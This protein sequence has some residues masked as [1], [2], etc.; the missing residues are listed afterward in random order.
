MKCSMKLRL[1]DKFFLIFCLLVIIPLIVVFIYSYLTMKSMIKNNII[2]S[3]EQ[4]FNQS[5]S[6]ISYKVDRL[7]N[8]I[9]S[10]I[11]DEN[12]TSIL[13]KDSNNYPISEQIEDLH[14]IRN[15]VYSYE[16][17][18]DI[19]DIEL[20][21]ND[22]FIFSYDKQNIYP[23]SFLE[24]SKWMSNIKSL[25]VSYYWAPYNYVNKN[26]DDYITVGKSIVNPDDYNDIIGYL[27]IKFNKSDLDEIINKINS[28]EYSFSCIVNSNNDVISLSNEDLYLKYKDIIESINNDLSLKDKNSYSNDVYIQS[29]NI[30]KTDWR[31]INIIP[32]STINSEIRIQL[33]YLISIALILGGADIIV[34]Y[35][36]FDSINTRLSK[37]VK[38]M[39]EVQADNLNHFIENDSDD[40]LGELIDT[41]NYMISKMSKLISDQYKYGKAVKNAELKALQSQINPHF[42]YNTLDMINW[43]AY[44]NMNSEISSA[45]KSLAKFYKLSLNKG[46]DLTYI[47]D[48]ISHVSLYV[49][50][51]NMR[52][53]DRISF[54][55]DIP[56]EINHY[57]I[58]KITLQPIVDNSINHGIFAKGNVTGKISIVAEI[59]KE[60]IYLKVIDDGIGIEKEKIP[61][62]LSSSDIKTTGSGYGL[63]NINQRLQ[64]LY[65]ES[66]GIFFESIYGQGTTVTIKIPASI[67]EGDVKVSK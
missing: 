46:N 49:K 12:L 33:I 14:T 48:E 32:L 58:P 1:A 37:V 44:K 26:I 34:G 4:A 15:Y 27:F 23:I 3:S 42:L 60:E 22:N 43:M 30:P 19:S 20:Y 2:T 64:L 51:Q 62:L 21:V 31:I 6:F 40:E 18:I 63:K 66:Y 7:Y 25:N 55:T 24:D 54:E 61:L 17:N 8:T 53:K 28:I 38:G 35:N 57:L 59:I 50:I 5:Y 10:L 11:I 65:G 56:E 16:N 36:F 45:V 41:Y 52:Y 9:N 13:L 47:S 39:R 29:S 67:H